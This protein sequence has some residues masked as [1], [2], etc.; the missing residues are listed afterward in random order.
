MFAG[1]Y[2]IALAWFAVG[3]F[4]VPAP[5]A[6]TALWAIS[7]FVTGLGWGMILCIPGMRMRDVRF[8]LAFVLS[9]LFALTPVM[10]PVELV[11]PAWAWAVSVNPLATIV[12]SFRS[13]LLGYKG[14]SVVREVIAISF[15]TLSFSA[16]LFVFHRFE[17]T[18]EGR[19]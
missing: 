9:A 14:P 16:G 13:G 10:Y 3:D 12:E 7:A 19:I 1:T 18:I 2:L 8:T 4:S 15:A 5:G 6:L 11:A 17:N